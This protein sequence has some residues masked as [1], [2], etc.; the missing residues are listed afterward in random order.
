MNVSVAD[1]MTSAILK[2]AQSYLARV[3]CQGSTGGPNGIY[4][5]GSAI[6]TAID[7]YI[8]GKDNR[9]IFQSHVMLMF[10]DIVVKP[11][12]IECNGSRDILKDVQHWC[13]IPWWNDNA[14][15]TRNQ[16]IQAFT[17]V[18]KYAQTVEDPKYEKPVAKPAKFEYISI[19]EACNIDESTWVEVTYTP[20]SNIEEMVKADIIKQFKSTMLGGW[21]SA[22]IVND[23]APYEYDSAYAKF[24]NSVKLDP[25]PP[26][27]PEKDECKGVLSTA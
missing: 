10:A 13:G 4:C 26:F 19:D 17:K 5:T 15:R 7:A 11:F 22:S 6:M 9:K 14:D 21:E 20:K 8:A 1:N 3:W 18:I 27:K 16:V 12:L 2:E 23:N 25:P 24:I